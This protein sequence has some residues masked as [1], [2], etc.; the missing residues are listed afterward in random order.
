MVLFIVAGVLVVGLMVA[1]FSLRDL[2]SSDTTS[3]QPQVVVT[4]PSATANAIVEPTMPEPTFATESPTPSPSA[5]PVPVT[6]ASI[7][8]I[9]PEGDGDEGTSSSAKAFDGDNSTFWG[10][11]TYKSA[12][13]GGL[14]KGVGLA[15]KLEETAVVSSATIKI[16]GSGGAVQLRTAD[17]P[18]LSSSTVIAK[19][20]FKNGK[21]SL[22]AENAKPS[23][24]VILWFTDL[25]SVDGKYKIE[26]SEV[27]LK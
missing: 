20:S 18:D 2:R 19:G 5:K 6:I 7:R 24:Y 16:N 8:A 13:F 1:A 23:R 26:V 10:S 21:A 27:Q 22:T 3:V 11:Q 25:P 4:L 15:L 14:K 12:R 9:D 17:A